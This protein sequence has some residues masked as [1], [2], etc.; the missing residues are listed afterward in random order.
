MSSPYNIIIKIWYCP[1]VV[2][3]FIHVVSWVVAISS[4]EEILQPVEML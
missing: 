3:R 2:T 4:P 1:W